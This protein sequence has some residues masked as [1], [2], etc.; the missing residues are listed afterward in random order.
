[1]KILILADQN[2]RLRSQVNFAFELSRN[3]DVDIMF[4]VACPASTEDLSLIEDI[5]SV[6]VK[7]LVSPIQKASVKNSQAID[8]KKSRIRKLVRGFSLIQIAYLLILIRKLF[9]VKALAKG[10]LTEY[11]P[12]VLVVNGDRGG[13]SFEQVFL[14]EA[15]IRN[16]KKVVPYSSVISDGLSLREK[17]IEDFTV[18][19]LFDR[20]VFHF[21]NNL[22]KEVCG[23]RIFFYD[24]S[25]AL[26]LK[27]YGSISKNPWMIGNGL[28]DVVCLDSS[29]AMNKYLP[30]ILEKSKYIP[31]G[32]IEY[33][34]LFESLKKKDVLSFYKKYK[35]EKNKKTI[36]VALPQ[37][38]EHKMMDWDTHWKEIRYI[39]SCLEK[40]GNNLVLSLHPKMNR[41]DYLFLENDYDCII[42]DEQLRDILAYAD[43][44]VAIN[45]STVLW[46]VILGVNTVLMDWYGLDSANFSGLTSIRYVKNK[47]ELSKVLSQSIEDEADFSNDWDILE[48]EKLFDGNVINRYYELLAG[49][50][51]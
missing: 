35:F 16:I 33:D 15:S 37:F 49:K 45:S 23:R 24:S 26:V 34:N 10:I 17:N 48:R 12:S 41:E 25:T 50:N 3:K 7:Y 8:T 28:A 30:E 47:N 11:S 40:Q 43:I 14:K 42:A 27:L 39:I 2:Q 18:R 20:L 6:K 38:A 1:M 46:A 5:P 36:A 19:T 44:F 29:F 22:T 4:L 31:V 21:T 9:K 32:D 51:E 13:V